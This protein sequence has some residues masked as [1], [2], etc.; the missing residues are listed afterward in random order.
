MEI[1]GIIFLAFFIEGLVEYLFNRDDGVKQPVLRYVALII[2]VALAIAYKVDI[3]AM[4]GLTTTIPFIGYIVSGIIIGRG[5]NYVNDAVSM[6]RG[7]QE[8]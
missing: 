1:G 8:A 5:S 7:K 4:V 2:G 6:L 3:L